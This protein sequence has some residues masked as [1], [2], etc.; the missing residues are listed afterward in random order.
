MASTDGEALDWVLP[1]LLVLVEDLKEG[2][3]WPHGLVCVGLVMADVLIAVGLSPEETQA[4]LEYDFV[5]EAEARV[6]LVELEGP[7]SGGS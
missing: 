3:D 6:C 1:R 5:G 7:D 2:V 4:Q